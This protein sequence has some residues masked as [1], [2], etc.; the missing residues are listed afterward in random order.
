LQW[1]TRTLSQKETQVEALRSENT[2]IKAR[3]EMFE[4]AARESVANRQFA[5]LGN[6]KLIK[7]ARVLT[8]HVV[9]VKKES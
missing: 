9:Q 8:P 7:A 3:L 4:R 2:S 5:T 6:Y 1:I